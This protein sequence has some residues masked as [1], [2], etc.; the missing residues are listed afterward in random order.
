MFLSFLSYYYTYYLFP[1]LSFKFLNFFLFLILLFISFLNRRPLSIHFLWLFINYLIL[2][3]SKFIIPHSLFLTYIPYHHIFHL[4]LIQLNHIFFLTI[5]NYRLTHGFSLL[6]ILFIQ[7]FLCLNCLDYFLTPLLI[8]LIVLHNIR[9]TRLFFLLIL[10]HF[11]IIFFQH[12]LST[13]L[14]FFLFLH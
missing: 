2:L 6:T 1:L 9:L 4:T 14:L 11:P 13:P 5:L 10:F 3:Y 12:I 8:I 7:I